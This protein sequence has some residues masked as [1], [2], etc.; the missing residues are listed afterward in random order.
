MTGNLAVSVESVGK[1]YEIYERPHHRLLQ[2]LFRGRRTY[3]RE[4]W[5]LRGVTF[6]VARGETV[7]VIGRNGSGKSTLLQLIAGTLT[8]TNGAITA[9][10]RIAALLELGSGFNPEFTGREN[11]FLNGAILGIS[12]AR[13]EDQFDAIAAFAAIGDFIDQP[14]KTYSSGMMVRLAFAV[15]VHVTPDLLIVD[16]ALAVGDTPFQAKCLHRIRTMQER[17]VSI[18]LVT[19]SLNTVI[20]FCERAVYLDRGRLVAA[21]RSREIVERYANDVVMQEGGIAITRD[22]AIG[23]PT[24]MQ[25]NSDI[26]SSDDARTELVAIATTDET[27]AGKTTFR[28]GETVIVELH[29]RF[30]RPNAA[31]CFGIQIKSPDDI[32]LWS[33][34]TQ[35]M[36]IRLPPVTEPGTIKFAWSLRANFGGGRYVVALGVGDTES[37]EYRRHSRAHYAAHFDVLSERSSGGG[38]LAPDAQFDVRTGKHEKFSPQPYRQHE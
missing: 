34:T 3:Y 17:G 10:G 20:E 11:V 23:V 38:W 37:G 29:V 15:A 14:V 28:R 27:G 16:E 36:D 4:F 7:G 8:P 35:L 9:A 6:D 25:P 30:N 26:V 33:A 18:L 13:M 24:G 12:R 2:T 31:P 22:P 32:V 5:A 21:G 19:H 1:R